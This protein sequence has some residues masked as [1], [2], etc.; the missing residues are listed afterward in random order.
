MAPG[1]VPTATAMHAAA[2]VAPTVTPPGLR[3]V[4]VRV[5][6]RCI[7]GGL[8]VTGGLNLGGLAPQIVLLAG[9]FK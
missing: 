8:S 6:R 2:A 4:V 7:K 1:A 9:F 3:N 5:A